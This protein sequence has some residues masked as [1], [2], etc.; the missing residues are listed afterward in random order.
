MIIYIILIYK[1]IYI[2]FKLVPIYYY[3]ITGLLS[4]QLNTAELP[5][6]TVSGFGIS[7]N[8]SSTENTEAIRTLPVNHCKH[9][10]NHVIC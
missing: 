6:F 8:M 2:H 9:N 3:I 7:M 4:R 10:V 1:N 5:S